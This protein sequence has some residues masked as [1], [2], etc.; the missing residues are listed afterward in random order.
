M[1]F[2]NTPLESLWYGF[3]W[4]TTGV[5]FILSLAFLLWSIAIFIS[6]RAYFRFGIAFAILSMGFMAYEKN[7]AKSLIEEEFHRKQR[8]DEQ[9]QENQ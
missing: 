5:A 2:K 4:A 1:D 6:D 7:L 9:E 8:L 3:K